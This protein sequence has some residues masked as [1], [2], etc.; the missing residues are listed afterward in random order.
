MKTALRH[1]R[2]TY[3]WAD[4]YDLRQLNGVVTDRVEDV[5]QTVDDRDQSFHRVDGGGLTYSGH[6][7][8]A[9]FWAV[10]CVGMSDPF[11]ATAIAFVGWRSRR[12][13]TSRTDRTGD[14]SAKSRNTRNSNDGDPWGNVRIRRDSRKYGTEGMADDET[15]K[16]IV[17]ARAIGDRRAVAITITIFRSL[18][19][20]CRTAVVVH[21]RGL[22]PAFQVPRRRRD[23]YSASGQQ[24][25]LAPPIT[26][27]SAAFMINN[28]VLIFGGKP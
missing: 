7:V 16:T 19:K 21:V 1:K 17:R 2:M 10:W 25:L 24:L 22:L 11:G 23:D 15:R 13:L 6:L 27:S 18:A 3:L 4:D 14:Q 5:L 26:E 9:A 12:A 28:Y 8:R 20:P